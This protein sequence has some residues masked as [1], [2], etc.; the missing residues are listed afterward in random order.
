MTQ[1]RRGPVHAFCQWTWLLLAVGCLACPSPA[2]ARILKT[3]RVG[4]PGQPPSITV[5]SGFEYEN[6]GEE[7]QYGFPF[8][9]EYGLTNIIKVRAEPN[10][11][12]IRKRDGGTTSG[13]GDL[14]TAA[15]FEF[16]T[17][18]RHR[19]GLALEAL[20]KWPTART[21]D[22][23]TGK[24]DYT[25]GAIVSK[26]FVQCDTEVNAAYTWVGDPP[27]LSLKDTFEASSA[28]EWHLNGSLDLLGEAV[29]A[30][31]A[32]GRFR[33]HNSAL[34][35][36]SIG[37]PQQGLTESEFTLGVAEKSGE[38][39]KYEQGVVIKSDGTY[40]WVLAWEWDF[41]GGR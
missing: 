32:G 23:G 2:T 1:A 31:G 40:Q 20:I 5:G 8:L 35:I 25:L 41:G 29:T 34:G 33:I 36:A 13:M 39:L 37:G 21:G 11:V 12:L 22:L 16:P 18:R 7:S 14:E 30:G 4:R 28:I 17:E 15:T 3:R 10:F 24:T 26:E 27:G 19:P 38:F 6:D 9:A